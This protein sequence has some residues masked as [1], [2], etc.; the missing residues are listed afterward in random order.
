M[1]ATLKSLTEDP[2]L[3]NVTRTALNQIYAELEAE[4]DK[5]LHAQPVHTPEARLTTL[6]SYHDLLE[7]LEQEGDLY[8]D[9]LKLLA[10]V[11]TKRVTIDSLSPHFVLL[12]IEWR[13]PVWGTDTAI[14]WRPAGR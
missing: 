6:L 3:P 10:Q 1:Q 2:N 11:T 5:L 14:L 13:T 9:D 7:K 12:T 8:F 4:K